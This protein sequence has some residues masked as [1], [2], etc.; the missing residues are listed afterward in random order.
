MEKEFGILAEWRRQE[1][2]EGECL[3]LKFQKEQE[4]K[5]RPHCKDRAGNVEQRV[6]YGDSEAPEQFVIDTTDPV[7]EIRYYCDGEEILLSEEVDRRSFTDKAI[8][9]KIVIC[10]RNFFFSGKHFAE[11]QSQMELSVK[12]KECRKGISS[13]SRGWILPA[14]SKEENWKKIDTDTY[15]AT[16]LFEKDANYIAE[17]T[18]M[19]LAG[20]KVSIAPRR[21]TVDQTAPKGE[22]IVDGQEKFSR[23]MESCFF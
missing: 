18:Y 10:E 12:Q 7:A 8:E 17:F 22:I 6:D 1:G 5:I 13:G 16:F 21:F 20:R 11:A 14:G 9:A 15:T 23:I 19:D 4:Y 3:Y 2:K